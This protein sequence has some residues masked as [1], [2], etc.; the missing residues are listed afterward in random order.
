MSQTRKTRIVCISDTH[1]QT[2]KL[3]P[4]DVLIHA[5]DLT[6]QGS[7]SELKKTVEWLEKT[8]YEAKIV[9]AGMSFTTPPQDHVIR[10]LTRANELNLSL[11]QG[12]TIRHSILP[13]STH[14]PTNSN[15]LAHKT[16][17]YVDRC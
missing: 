16:Q 14:L 12:T 5:G 10:I 8:D 1:N 3:P 2:P 7:Y 17:T 9:V 15:G 4:G 11:H 13:S 6:N